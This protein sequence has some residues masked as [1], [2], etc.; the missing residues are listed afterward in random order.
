MRRWPIALPPARRTS[1]N[2]EY[3]PAVMLSVSQ[4]HQRSG[5]WFGRRS[6]RSRHPGCRS[7][8]AGVGLSSLAITPLRARKGASWRP[9]ILERRPVTGL[10]ALASCHS[11][12]YRDP[13]IPE[14]W[15]C[16]RGPLNQSDA[17]STSVDHEERA[18]PAGP[19]APC[20]CAPQY[21]Q[22]ATTF[23]YGAAISGLQARRRS[24]QDQDRHQITQHS[25]R[26]FASELTH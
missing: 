5:P 19:I 2:P 20:R 26:Y 11:G 14:R 8:L 3:G 1:A 18:P 7:S 12:A 23:R 24:H 17:S 22:E 15:H 10:R 25:S 21:C 16:L 4:F 6:R 13:V 9:G